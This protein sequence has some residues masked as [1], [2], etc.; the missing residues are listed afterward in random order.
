MNKEKIIELLE[1]A[2]KGSEEVY[3]APDQ[4][5]ITLE[6]AGEKFHAFVGDEVYRAISQAL[7]FL[8]RDD[9]E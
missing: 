1:T 8:K 6:E 3:N 5:E 2:L 9:K 7:V 4:E